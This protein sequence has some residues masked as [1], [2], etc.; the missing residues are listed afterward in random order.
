M[1]EAVFIRQNV[2][3]WK[4]MEEMVGDE[5]FTTPDDV[6]WAYNEITSDLAFA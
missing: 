3:K 6:V 1:Q 2:E 5:L 4:R